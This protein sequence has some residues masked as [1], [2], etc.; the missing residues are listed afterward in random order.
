MNLVVNHLFPVDK[1]SVKVEMTFKD[2]YNMLLLEK[3]I[4]KL[5]AMREP[6]VKLLSEDFGY[7]TKKLSQLFLKVFD[8]SIIEYHR[9]FHMKY[10]KWLI[11]EKQMQIIE[12]SKKLGFNSTNLF[13]QVFKRHY[14]YMPQKCKYR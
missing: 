1:V 9:D 11:E 14:F 3:V 4:R 13:A 2:F 10:A 6:N 5:P 7:S 8:V 12:V